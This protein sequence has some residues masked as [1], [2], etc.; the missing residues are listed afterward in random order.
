M[1][2]PTGMLA[3][4][5]LEA[6]MLPGVVQAAQVVAVAKAEVAN[7]VAGEMAVAAVEEENLVVV[8]CNS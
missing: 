1:H 4:W 7:L 5:V 8:A 3:C 6:G 2:S